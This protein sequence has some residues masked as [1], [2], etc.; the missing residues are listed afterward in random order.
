MMVAQAAGVDYERMIAGEYKLLILSLIHIL[1]SQ[2]SRGG[3]S[4]RQEKTHCRP[5]RCA[6]RHPCDS[7]CRRL[8][9]ADIGQLCGMETGRRHPRRRH[10]SGGSVARFFYLPDL[11]SPSA[12]WG[13]R[14]ADLHWPAGDPAAHGHADG[15][16]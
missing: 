7:L 4:H 5:D 15:L 9:G 14:G 8:S 16:Q 11:C 10:I 12:L 6:V 2:N 13:V 3:C 1:I